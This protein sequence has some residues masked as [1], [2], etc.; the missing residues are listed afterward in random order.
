MGTELS[1]YDEYLELR[2]ITGDDIVL[3]ATP[4]SL[5]R[6]DSL[7][8]VLSTGIIERYGYYL[9]SRRDT[10][11]SRL[12][13]EPD[14][15]SGELVLPNSGAEYNL[16][17]GADSTCTLLDRVD[18]SAG[19]PPA[20]EYIV[21]A[22]WWSMERNQPPGDGR[23]PSNWHTACLQSGWDAGA[24]ERGT[25]K[26]PNY[27]NI[28][29]VMPDSVALTP[30]AVGDDSTVICD[31]FGA[32]DPDMLP[33]RARC[34]FEWTVGGAVRFFDVDSIE[35]YGSFLPADSTTPGD[36]FHLRILL[37]DGVDSSAYIDGGEF[38]VHYE[39]MDIVINEL[40]WA[41]S[42]NNPLGEWIELKNRSDGELDFAKTPFSLYYRDY[43]G[44]W[45]KAFSLRDGIVPAGAYYIVG[46]G[47]ADAC[48]LLAEP[49]A[50]KPSLRLSDVHLALRLYDASSAPN[51]WLI[52]IAG[53][54]DAPFAGRRDPL[55]SVLSTMSRY[56]ESPARGDNAASWFAPTTSAG[57]EALSLERGTPGFPNDATNGIPMVAFP[58][59]FFA[60]RT[61]T[62]DTTFVV[63]ALWS[64]PDGEFPSEIY[65]LYDKDYNGVLGNI[66]DE[67][68]PMELSDSSGSFLAEIEHP[69]MN[70][71]GIHLSVRATDGKIWVRSPIPPVVGPIVNQTL[72]VSISDTIWTLDTVTT[73]RL[74]ISP[75]FTIINDG[76]GAESYGLQ[77]Q[78]ADTF[79]FDGAD[80]SSN[81]GLTYVRTPHA[82]D[83]NRYCLS[84][85]FL[86]PPALIHIESD[87]NRLGNEDVLTDARIF[88]VGETLSVRE[89]SCG[90][91]VRVADTVKLY[92]RLDMPRFTI[93]THKNDPHLIWVKLWLRPAMP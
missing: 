37:Y 5:Y 44:N 15:V 16:Y 90:A 58:E 81:G 36:S 49:D 55:D 68:L 83:G 65:L 70:L 62:R 17:D 93:G 27:R 21:S 71:S 18:Y 7:M 6:N 86:P 56:E 80:T 88:A 12:A 42:W 39:P 79:L 3:S 85:I 87:F 13:I 35:P 60:P 59:P 72:S 84:G 74:A 22:R 63:T 9:I 45:R 48:G 43:A 2:N 75:P 26:A 78:R 28:P 76:D 38:Y 69:A 53:D 92:L 40:G 8:L 19:A 33:M 54:G 10:A 91:V 52:D 57:F 66:P 64:D 34:Y 25:P 67:W 47:G 1:P 14:I 29:P 4:L 77:I 73:E 30:S 20:G 50:I 51:G 23:D 82:I 24:K 11:H 31:A 46:R 61:G 32:H 89:S 41:G